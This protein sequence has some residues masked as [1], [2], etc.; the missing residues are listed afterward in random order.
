MNNNRSGWMSGKIKE[1]LVCLAK[2]ESEKECEK[3][4]RCGCSLVITF[5]HSEGEGE[6]VKGE[7]KKI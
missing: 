2:E 4:K 7:K 6:R 1:W 5:M 3:R